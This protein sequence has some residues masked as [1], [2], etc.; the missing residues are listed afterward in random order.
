MQLVTDV[1]NQLQ[2]G[3]VQSASAYV[4]PIGHGHQGNI[5]RQGEDH[6]AQR[7]RASTTSG[8]TPW[9]QKE[10]LLAGKLSNP[11]LQYLYQDKGNVPNVPPIPSQFYNNAPGQGPRLGQSQAVNNSINQQG[12]SSTGPGQNP[13]NDNFLT[14]P[15][16][17]PTL[18]ATK[19][20]NPVDF[21]TRP[22]FVSNHPVVLSMT[23]FSRHVL[24]FV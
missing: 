24:I 9:D 14:S 19:G 18:I 20:Y 4:P 5:P 1:D 3:S 11:N 7:E 2:Q 15:L 21:D 17:V 6:H 16:D 13:A 8:S 12:R 23:N 22:F 10:R